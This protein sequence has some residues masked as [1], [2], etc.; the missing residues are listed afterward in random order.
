MRGKRYNLQFKTPENFIDHE[1]ELL[2]FENI[3]M[4]DIIDNIKE[5]LHKYYSI[6]NM[7]ISN[8]MIY[9]LYKGGLKTDRKANALL[10]FFCLVEEV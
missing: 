3:L 8:Q 1:K 7:K 6:E 10:R 5:S 2:K 9:N 4:E